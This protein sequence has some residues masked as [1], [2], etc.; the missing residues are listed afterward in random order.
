MKDKE[1]NQKLISVI[2]PFHVKDQTLFNSV[3]QQIKKYYNQIKS[4]EFIIVF[5]GFKERKYCYEHCKKIKDINTNINCLYFKENVIIGH[6]RNIGASI[7]IGKYLIFMD[8]DVIV[9][10][11]TIKNIPDILLKLEEENYQALHPFLIPYKTNSIW[12]KLD[13]DE[14]RRSYLERVINKQESSILVGPF[15]LIKSDT[16]FEL[17]GWE[18]RLLC[19]EDR[20]LAI[21]LLNKGYKIKYEPRIKILHKNQGSLRKIIKRKIFHAEVNSLVYE[22]H[23]Y[24]YHKSLLDWYSLILSKLQIKHHIYGITYSLIMFMYMTAFF[25]FRIR[26]KLKFSS[27]LNFKYSRE[28]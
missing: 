4:I 22:R 20:D 26:F 24:Y 14:D 8:C 17:G 12:A 15:T 3:I 9:S 16:F 27:Y 10:K 23:N 11:N 7:A 13:S 6:A 2:I 25:Y 19:S 21:R 28:F 18:E 1:S 5:N